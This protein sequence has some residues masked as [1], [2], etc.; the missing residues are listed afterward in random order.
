M[1]RKSMS[2]VLAFVAVLVVAALGWL[3]PLARNSQAAPAP[4]SDAAFKGKVLLVSTTNMMSMFLLEKAQ[5]QRIGDRSWL[6]GKGAGLDGGNVGP[7]KGR[8]VR[9]QME[10][11]VSIT[12]YDSL[13]DFEKAGT[14]IIGAGGYSAAP[15]AVPASPALPGSPLRLPPQRKDP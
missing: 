11:I 1:N 12:E 3:L 8:T 13:K 15:I 14:A 10:H 7:Y 6:V 2:V 4:S 5:I 9:V